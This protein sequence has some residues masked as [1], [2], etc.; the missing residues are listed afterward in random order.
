MKIE[1]KKGISYTK[2][3]SLKY[4]AVCKFHFRSKNIQTTNKLH[5]NI[6][7]VFYS[8]YSHQYV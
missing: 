1:R 6:Y 8:I 5:F 7:E 2:T 4:F 3:Q